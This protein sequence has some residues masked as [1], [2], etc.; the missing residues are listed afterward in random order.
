[1]SNTSFLRKHAQQVF[2]WL[3]LLCKNIRNFFGKN[4][5]NKPLSHFP[6]IFV[7]CFFL[8]TPTLSKFAGIEGGLALSCVRQENKLSSTR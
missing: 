8:L 7:L 3:Y 5:D 2:R 4:S 1:M 6:N